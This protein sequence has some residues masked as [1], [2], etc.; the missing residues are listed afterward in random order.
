MGCHEAVVGNMQISRG[1]QEKVGRKSQGDVHTG[2]IN[3][4]SVSICAND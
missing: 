2:Y 3:G 4:M 1:E